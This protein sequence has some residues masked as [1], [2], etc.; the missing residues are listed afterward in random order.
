MTDLE[1]REVFL[2]NIQH[3]LETGDVFVQINIGKCVD[4]EEAHKIIVESLKESA[5]FLA[6]K[7]TQGIQC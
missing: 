1:K 2:K 3:D 6:F 5:E 7:I 4:K